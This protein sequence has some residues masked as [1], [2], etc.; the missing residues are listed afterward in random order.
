M[1]RL[2][3]QPVDEI[4]ESLDTGVLYISLGYST[5]IHLCACG[6]GVEVVTPLGRPGWSLTYD[7]TA[8]LHPSVGNG[9]FPCRS[10]Y[11][12]T[13]NSVEWLPPFG[14]TIKPRTK[15][16]DRRTAAWWIRLFRRS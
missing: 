16:A 3:P 2:R 9:N 7:G 4:P 8:S 13:Q 6:C 12:V 14:S 5:A 1:Q 15:R 11:Y 10:H